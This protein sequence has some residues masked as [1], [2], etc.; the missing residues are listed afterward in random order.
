PDRK[1][2]ELAT[3]VAID[4]GVPVDYRVLAGN[5]ADHTTPVENLRRLQ[6][7]LA[8]LPSRSPAE[9]PLVISDRAMLTDA[10]IAAYDQSNLCFLGPLD[11]SLGN[12]A[13]RALLE[14]VSVAE[15]AASPLTYRPQRAQADP[16][17]D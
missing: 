10:A 13:V 7:L 11:P 1:Q 2:L 9:R 17:W 14:S 4:G 5:V 3:T 15:L 6:G 12:G 16:D 8:L